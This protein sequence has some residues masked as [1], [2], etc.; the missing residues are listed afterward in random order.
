MIGRFCIRSQIL[1]ESR[2]EDQKGPKVG[3]RLSRMEARPVA[4][5]SDAAVAIDWITEEDQVLEAKAGVY[6]R[7]FVGAKFNT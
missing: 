7:W 6:G 2:H 5:W 1:C 3:Q 4:F